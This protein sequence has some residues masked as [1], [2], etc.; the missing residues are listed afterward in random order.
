MIIEEAPT[1]EAVIDGVIDILQN[2]YPRI[3]TELVALRKKTKTLFDAI[4]H[5]DDKHQEWLREA[6]NNHFEL[7]VE[8]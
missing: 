2:E 3:G 6:I 5:G 7:E 8:G 1:I 4:K